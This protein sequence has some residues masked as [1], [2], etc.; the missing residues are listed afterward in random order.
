MRLA[1]A[2]AHQID[3][4]EAEMERQLVAVQGAR[5]RRDRPGGRAEPNGA[6]VAAKDR[7]RQRRELLLRVRPLRQP[8]QRLLAGE[9]DDDVDLR[10]LVQDV[11][12][13][14]AREMAAADDAP[15]KAPLAEHAG[16]RDRRQRRLGVLDGNAEEGVAGG[17]RGARPRHGRLDVAPAA[18]RDDVMR[19]TRPSQ[20]AAQRRERVVLH[21]RQHE[22]GQND[23][24]ATP[25]DVIVTGSAVAIP[26]LGARAREAS[27]PRAKRAIA[28][29]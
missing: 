23:A 7:S 1:A 6:V 24:H 18:E 15:A 19:D 21:V 14:Q 11:G 3:G 28:A 2:A 5:N 27:R 12:R 16:E 26:R 9:A 8:Q 17:L 29:T 13:V 22:T 10:N 20:R 4:A 25:P